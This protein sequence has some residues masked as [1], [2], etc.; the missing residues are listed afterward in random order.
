MSVPCDSK[1]RSVQNIGLGE[2]TGTSYNHPQQSD[3]TDEQI[4]EGLD[5]YM[6]YIDKCYRIQSEYRPEE[7]RS[8]LD[9]FAP[10]LFKHLDEEV[11]SLKGPNMSK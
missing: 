6:A 4:H 5:R 7:L 2:L 11:E 1:S 10:V 9:S 8:I 3:R